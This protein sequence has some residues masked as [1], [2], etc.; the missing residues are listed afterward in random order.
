[1]KQS[2]PYIFEK[3]KR[4]LPNEKVLTLMPREL[5]KEFQAFVFKKNGDSVVIA[6]V[7]PNHSSLK[8]FVRERFDNKVE[9]FLA[10]EDD[11]SFVLD[12]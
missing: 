11:I 8:G 5:V 1:M 10:K 2:Y 6:A 4:K 3:K 9:W 12:N 7:D